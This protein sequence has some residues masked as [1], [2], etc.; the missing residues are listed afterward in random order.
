MAFSKARRLSDSISATG[1]VSAFVDGA[2]VAADLNSTLDLTGKTITVANAS[3][4]DSD[5]TV[6]NTAFVQQ[7]IAALVA[8]APGTLNTLNELAAALGDDASFSTTVTNSIA[9]KL[10][11]AG[12]TLTGNLL[13]GHTSSFA[14]ADADNLAIGDGTNNSGLT[15]Y[16]GASKESSIIFGNAGTNGNIEAGIKYYHESH[17]TVANRRAMTFATGGSMAERMR[18][19]SSGNVGIGDISP[20]A[21]LTVKAA[22]DTIRAESLA[23]DAKN[24]TMSYHDGND[25][26][27][28]FCGQDGVVDKNIVLRG[29]TLIFQRNGGTSA[30]QVRSDG[31]VAIG[32]N[33]AGY[34]SQILSVKSGAADE[35]LYGES[36]DANCFAVFRD[37]SSNTNVGFGAIGNDHVFRNDSTE[38]W[39]MQASNGYLIGQSASQVRLVLGS[40][41][42]SSNNTSNW[43]RGDGSNL[44]RNTPG[45][46]IWEVS[47]AQVMRLDGDGLRFGTDTAAAN[48]LDDY[49]EG[50]WSP[51]LIGTS[52]SAG[53]YARNT[54]N[55]NYTKVGR[56]VTIQCTFYIT[57]KGSYG[58]KTRLTGLPFA[59]ATS[60]TALTLG[61]FPDSGYG[62]T[63]GNV[64]ISAAVDG[65]QTYVA[66]F[67]GSRLDPRHDYA[68]VG[69]GY[70]IN[71][72][73]SYMAAT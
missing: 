40:T 30:M 62:T 21:K 71:L 31:G 45:D 13:I 8:S 55:A 58:G 14:H 28:I 47:G 56:V 34:S 27:Q 10:P 1:E 65:A 32:S 69:T 33:N 39:R 18:I 57:N 24:I 63:S 68:D 23:T 50:T 59:A 37:N 66:F 54:P 72:A 25:Q 43:I 42:N 48:A 16:T 3:T 20:I 46:H 7:E 29:H 60:T 64:L 36:T 5:T 44:G 11:L 17:G 70:Y 12:G 53:S 67:D 6:A 49:E 52:G 38:K 9:T 15:I 51:Q 22:A 26:G 73:G 2:I 4:G 35:V 61:S 41:G 19:N